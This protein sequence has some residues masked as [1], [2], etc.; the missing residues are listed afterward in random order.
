[1][2]KDVQRWESEHEHLPESGETNLRS[3]IATGLPET[4]RFLGTLYR[5]F[6]NDGRRAQ[7]AK[8][9]KSKEVI[10][11]GITAFHAMDPEVSQAD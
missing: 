4:R 10:P 11:Q 6:T 9:V 2:S 3:A 7:I 8:L 5:E 1:M